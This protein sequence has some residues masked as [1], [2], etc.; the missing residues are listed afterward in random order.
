MCTKKCKKKEGFEGYKIDFVFFVP[1][2]KHV[3]LQL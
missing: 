2:K 3:L 1:G